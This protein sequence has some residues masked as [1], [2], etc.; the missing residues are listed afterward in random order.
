MASYLTETFGRF[1]WQVVQLFGIPFVLAVLLQHVGRRI[2]RGGVGTLGDAYW[3]FVAPGVAC[4][5]TGHAV[6]CLLTGTKITKFVPFCRKGDGTLGYVQHQVGGGFFW[7]LAEF[8]IAS[9]PVWFGCVAFV[10]LTKL[11]SGVA[12]SIRFADYFAA[13]ELPGLMAYGAGLLSA[14]V[15][16]LGDVVNVD[17]WGWGFA[18]WLYLSFCIASE[19][20]LSSVDLKH[21]W[22]G[23]I[24]VLA[25]FAVANCI[26][27]LGR[28]ISMAIYVILPYLF[29]FHVIMAVALVANVILLMG[30]ALV[31]KRVSALI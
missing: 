14:A 8:L 19:I 7:P 17:V 1:V 30:V 2:R 28:L 18:I 10:I 13:D 16:F 4:H 24:G 26:P 21:M 20:G 15:A 3:Y 27:P 6:G 31:S 25:A 12:P 23:A 11:F 5:E 9:G 22:R 29:K